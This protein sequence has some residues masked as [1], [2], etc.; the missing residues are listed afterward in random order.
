VNLISEEKS[1]FDYA[2]HQYN[3]KNQLLSTDYYGNNDILSSDLLVY[4][5]CLNRKEWVTPVNGTKGGTIKY[6]YNSNGQLIKTTYS[7]P[8]NSISEYS[9]FSY[10][11]DNRIS[12]Q[13]IYWE[14]AKTGYTDY[15]YDSKGNLIKEIL[16]N[17]LSTGV[18]ELSTTI[19]YE[20]DNEH[21]PYELF[22]GLVVPG[23]YTNYNNIIRETYTIN[24]G[25]TQGTSNT[26]V[27]DNKYAYN[28]KGFPVSKNNNVE[29]VYK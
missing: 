15:S 9:E 20:F 5:S 22:S 18:A 17:V 26:Q 1:K 23:I 13:T 3:D 28:G 29:Y 10:D 14:N 27:T 19:T 11:A 12:R 16:Y 6:D 4:E 7:R 24:S 25:A 8:L 21:N 2:L